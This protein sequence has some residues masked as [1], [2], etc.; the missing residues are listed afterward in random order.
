MTTS[1]K[2]DEYHEIFH[3]DNFNS[4]TFSAGLLKPLHPKTS[5]RILHS[6]LYTFLKMLMRRICSTIK[7]SLIGDYFLHSH[8]LNV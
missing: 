5:I 1:T 3:S 6:A 7:I 8:D 2:V 4:S